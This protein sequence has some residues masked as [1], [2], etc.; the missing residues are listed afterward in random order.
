[1]EPIAW[2]AS[3]ATVEELKSILFG[4]NYIDY[5]YAINMEDDTLVIVKVK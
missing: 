4:L 5:K 1:M 2:L 3:E